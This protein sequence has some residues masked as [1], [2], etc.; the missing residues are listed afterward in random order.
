[1]SR[2]ETSLRHP[3]TGGL[4]AVLQVR[5]FEGASPVSVA[6]GKYIL[7]TASERQAVSLVSK[8]ARAWVDAGASYICAWGPD[9][10]GA[11]GAGD[12]RMRSHPRAQA[13]SR[14]SA[15]RRGG[16]KN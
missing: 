1:M 3:G 7:V 11:G 15:P 2:V 5:D 8:T 16:L 9:R 4:A 6:A 10:R 13:G 14:S 12:P